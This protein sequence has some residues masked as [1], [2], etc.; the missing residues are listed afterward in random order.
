M[1]EEAPPELPKEVGQRLSLGA[2]IVLKA[3]RDP[4]ARLALKQN[5]VNDLT[6]HWTLLLHTFWGQSFCLNQKPIRQVLCHGQR[7]C[8]GESRA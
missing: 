5:H 4:E 7:D 2:Q 1:A 8:Q 3:L 6:F